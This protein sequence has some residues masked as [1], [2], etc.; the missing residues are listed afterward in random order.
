MNHSDAK[1]FAKMTRDKKRKKMSTEVMKIWMRRML[2]KVIKPEY[3]IL[4]CTNFASLEMTRAERM[5]FGVMLEELLGIV[6]GPRRIFNIE[7]D[8]TV[9]VAIA[10]KCDE[11]IRKNFPSLLSL[12]VEGFPSAKKRRVR[13]DEGDTFSLD[14]PLIDWHDTM[15]S[16]AQI[17]SIRWDTLC[18]L[19]GGA[20]KKGENRGTLS[21]K[22]LEEA[23]K[24][25]D[26]IMSLLSDPSIFDPGYYSK[27]GLTSQFFS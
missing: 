8:K 9:D 26:M 17:S 25:E 7:E 5:K 20:M 1:D 21:D 3:Y 2:K 16:I 22:C 19:K 10:K 23:D 15:I 6:G 11:V 13:F 18:F 14:D 27:D 12:D 4:V 24:A